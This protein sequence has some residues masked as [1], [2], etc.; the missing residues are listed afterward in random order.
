MSQPMPAWR[1]H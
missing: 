1:L